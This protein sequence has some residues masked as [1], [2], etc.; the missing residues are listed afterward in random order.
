MT[1]GQQFVKMLRPAGCA[2]FLIIFAAF[3]VMCFTADDAPIKG[4]AVPQDS[5]YYA[6]HIDELQSE[7]EE[8]VFPRLDGVV[9]SEISD[10]I[11]RITVESEELET[12]KTAITHYY[13][14]ALFE[15]TEK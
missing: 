14:E 10:G 8:N 12:V 11:L 15:F 6:E 9:S 1:A 2:V 7:L 13:S 5:E 3:M 4:Y